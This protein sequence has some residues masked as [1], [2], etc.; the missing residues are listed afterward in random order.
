MAHYTFTT[1]WRMC[2]TADEVWDVLSDVESL[3]DWWSAVYL[4]VDVLRRGNSDGVGKTVQL[5]TRGKLPYTLRWQM[6]VVDS[7]RPHNLSVEATGDL[8]GRGVWTFEQRSRD[9][10]ITYDWS[11]RA[12]KPLLRYLSWLAIYLTQVAPTCCGPG[13]R[14]TRG[15]HRRAVVFGD[16]ATALHP[17][18]A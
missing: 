4:D 15:A 8:V 10:D 2:A 12:D 18:T 5:L 9:L 3:T 7:N 16:Q 14:Q 1:H 13:L 11:V 6:T 17:K